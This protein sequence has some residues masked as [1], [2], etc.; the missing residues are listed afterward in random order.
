MRVGGWGAGV[1]GECMSCRKNTRNKIHNDHATIS[2]SFM[3]QTPPPS[4][5]KYSPPP[6][7]VG[8]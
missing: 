3:S 6:L 4:C 8:A 1:E 5:L 2:H 7:Q